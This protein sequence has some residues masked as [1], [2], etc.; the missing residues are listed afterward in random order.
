MSGLLDGLIVAADPSANHLTLVPG[1]VV[2]DQHQSRDFASGEVL[3]TRTQEV[4]GDGADRTAIHEAQQHLVGVQ[5]TLAQEQ[6]VT[7]QSFGIGVLL[8]AFQF[9]KVGHGICVFPAVLIGLGQPTPPHF[10]AETQRPCRMG[11]DQ[12]DQSVP[13]VFFLT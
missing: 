4:D 6:S 2:P 12:A 7:G 10:I 1:G 8:A 9:L 13:T 5:G 11:Q 3:T